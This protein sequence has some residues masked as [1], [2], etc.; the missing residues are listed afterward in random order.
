MSP[1][2]LLRIL[3]VVAL[4]LAIPAAFFG[5]QAYTQSASYLL[6][7]GNEAISKM[8]RKE[9]DRI[10]KLLEAKG[11]NQAASFIHGKYL[12]F[13]GDA[14][15]RQT[16]VPPPFEEVQQTAQYVLG[17]AGLCNQITIT[18]QP[19]WAYASF[20][21]KPLNLPSPALNA[22]RI[23]LAELAK[24]QNDGP[25]GVEGTILGAECLVR[26]DEKR[27][28]EESLKAVVQ[29]HPDNRDAHRM[30]A[31]IY[32]DLNSPGNAIKHLEEW[33]RLDPSDGLPYR[34]IG[35]FRK[36]GNQQTEA[37]QA[38]QE[39]LR[40]NLKPDM[41]AEALKELAEIYLALEDNP[42]LALETLA[43]GPES[44][45]RDPDVLALRVDCLVNLGH[46]AEAS[47]V[48]EQAHR[49]NPHNSKI[50]V[51]RAQMF[52]NEN[53]A[54]QAR[55]LL[56]E[57]VRL[58][59]LNLQAQSM[60]MKAYGQLQQPELAA[61]QKTKVEEVTKIHVTLSDLRTK[62][63]SSPW[64]ANVRYEMGEI[65]LKNGHPE[66]ARTWL[67]AALACNPGHAKARRLLNKI[68][69]NEKVTK[70]SKAADPIK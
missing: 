21:Q 20:Y 16:Q 58:D 56:E 15:L 62:A 45:Q 47:G 31:G 9:F 17:A 23:A 60:L 61:K 2:L 54:D 32:I 22:F 57:A 55:P 37:I 27:M 8:D 51:M 65:F 53:Q 1:I 43:Q 25:I 11:E 66:D 33:A 48:M 6:A 36:D 67:Q 29:R 13:A 10:Q 5:Y 19:V 59:P 3:L 46:A 49:N 38:Y 14:L 35:F 28:A 42:N 44:F 18:R 63:V 70:A 39:A 26:L 40:R 7:Q 52:L 50:V 41:R 34:W 69:P 68:P 12:V 4:L 30:L 64:D 24:I